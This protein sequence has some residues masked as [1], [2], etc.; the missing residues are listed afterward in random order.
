MSA[1]ARLKVVVIGAAGRMGRAIVAAVAAEPGLELAGATEVPGHPEL[2]KDAGLL[3]GTGELGVTITDEL[4]PLLKDKPV[5]I[6]FTIP[7]STVTTVKACAEAGAPMVIGTTGLTDDDKAVVAKLAEKAPVVMAPNMSIGVNALI[8]LVEEAVKAAGET[9]DI[10]IVETHHRLKKDA[11]SGTALR[12]A[13]AAAAAR[14]WDLS[15]VANFHR[16]GMIGQRPDK[17]IGIQTLRAGDVVGEHTVMLA[18]PGER[19]ELT[20]KAHGRD[21]FARGAARAAAWLADKDPGLYD[22][23]DV[24]GIKK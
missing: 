3:A 12:L 8:H 16:E 17:E 13:E 21:V 24:L 6:D 10:E 4:S 20:H 14:G 2:G 15:E 7:A 9:F 22:M 1:D 23:R 5:V 18:G 19:I 11:P